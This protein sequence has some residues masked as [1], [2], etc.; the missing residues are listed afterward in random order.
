MKRIITYLKTK[1]TQ[2]CQK[3]KLYGR[4]TMKDLKKPYS[5]RQV[6]GMKT[7]SQGGEDVVWWWQGGGSEAVV[8]AVEWAVPH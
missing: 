1:T 2:N 5:F 3:I 6:E 4:P 8:A 7:G